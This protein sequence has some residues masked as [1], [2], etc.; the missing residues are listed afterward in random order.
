MR[1]SPE[2]SVDGFFFVPKFLPGATHIRFMLQREPELP[3]ESYLNMR[4]FTYFVKQRGGQENIE[5]T[6]AGVDNQA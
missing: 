3:W 1:I 5:D 6:L 2:S 4:M